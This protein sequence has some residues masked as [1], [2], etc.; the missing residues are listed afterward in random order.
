MTAVRPKD[1]NE[2]LIFYFAF[3]TNIT[4]K[5]LLAFRG[6]Y[7]SFYGPKIYCD[8]VNPVLRFAEHTVT[9]YTLKPTYAHM[10]SHL[11]THT[12]KHT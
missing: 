9:Q 6:I 12:H 1:Q 8:M 10:Y 7:V 3:Y 2:R 11:H 5:Y 4:L